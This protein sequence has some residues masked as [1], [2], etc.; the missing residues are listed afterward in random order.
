MSHYLVSS[1]FFISIG[2]LLAARVCADHFVDVVVVEPEAW[3]ATEEGKT[4]LFDAEGLP[5]AAVRSKRG[6]V[7]Q[8]N[9]I[10]G[11]LL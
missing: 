4:S 1:F 7:F 6:R 11:M 10:H 2:G 5:R 9:A 3:L 8:Y